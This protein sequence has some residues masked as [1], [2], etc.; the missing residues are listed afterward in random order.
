MFVVKALAIW[1]LMV[2]AAIVNGI[3]RE[4]FLNVY[5]GESNAL[6][7]SGVI[8]SLLIVAI[9]Y[10]AIDFF[11]ARSVVIYLALGFFWVFLT[12]VFEYGFGHFVQGMEFRE[13]N[14]AFNLLSGNLFILVIVVT[15]FSPLVIAT[16]KG[17]VGK[18]T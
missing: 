17:Y 10:E 1:V 12:L 6:P 13:I 16:I 8:L 9:T 14:Q 18:N 3:F 7:L 11:Q 4:K 2:F 15:L 5:L